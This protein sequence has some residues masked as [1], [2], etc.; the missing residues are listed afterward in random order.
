MIFIKLIECFFSFSIKSSFLQ[1]FCERHQFLRAV[2]SFAFSGPSSCIS[3]QHTISWRAS[4]TSS[5]HVTLMFS[6]DRWAFLFEWLF[7]SLH[8]EVSVHMNKSAFCCTSSV[9][10]SVYILIKV[11]VLYCKCNYIMVSGLNL[12][13]LSLQK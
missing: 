13:Q 4:I 11:K 12:F 3:L 1:L 7:A 8:G 5:V 9:F 6:F 10:F 2:H